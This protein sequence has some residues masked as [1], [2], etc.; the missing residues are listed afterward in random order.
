MSGDG[1]DVLVTASTPY[2]FVQA[3]ALSDLQIDATY[4]DGDYPYAVDVAP[5][6]TM[7]IAAHQFYDPALFFYLPGS[8]TAFFTE[9]VDA[10]GFNRSVGLSPDI[11][12]VFQVRN[13]EGQSKFVV[14]LG[15]VNSFLALTADRGHPPLRR[16]V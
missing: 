2:D 16:P 7:V 9:V 11:L 5:D 15:P 12:W 1:T 3:F 13:G 8:A 6:G 14:Q 4:G 10:F